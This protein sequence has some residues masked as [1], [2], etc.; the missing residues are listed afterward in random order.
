MDVVGGEVGQGAAASVLV[1]DPRGPGLSGG[2]G[3]VATA[4]SLDRGLLV[5]GEYVLVRAQ[6]DAVE[7]AGIQ[8]HDAGGL[9]PELRIADENPGLVLPGLECV[10]AQPA[11]DGG[12]G[13]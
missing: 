6:R 12:G 13:D 3:G 11:A 8:V 5:A 9:G 7:G 2:E 1:V 10:L 4:T